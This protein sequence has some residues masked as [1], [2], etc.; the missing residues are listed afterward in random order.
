MVM[1]VVE[2]HESCRPLFLMLLYRARYISA[3]ITDIHIFSLA[4]NRNVVQTYKVMR[5]CCAV[6]TRDAS[7]TVPYFPLQ[8]NATV[9]FCKLISH[10]RNYSTATVDDFW[11]AMA[12]ETIG[13]P[14]EI[15]VAEA[16]NSWISH[17]GYP[18]VSVMRK[19]KEGTAVIRQ[20]RL[21]E[22]NCVFSLLRKHDNLH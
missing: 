10:F 8:K 2:C 16:M 17:R 7:K 12:E 19:Y 1:P 18:I 9:N 6:Y 14:I 5:C 13:L 22:L 21:K 11:E 3:P 15:T 4:L 20:V